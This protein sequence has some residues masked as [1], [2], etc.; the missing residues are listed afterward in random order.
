M[1]KEPVFPCRLVTSNFVAPLLGLGVIAS[2][3]KRPVLK[4]VWLHRPFAAIRAGVPTTVGA[5][6]F[7]KGVLGLDAARVFFGGRYSLSTQLVAFF[8]LLLVKGEPSV[9]LWT[10]TL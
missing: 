1:F 6:A 3:L 10:L 8:L 2:T 9:D 7:T 4:S 5:I